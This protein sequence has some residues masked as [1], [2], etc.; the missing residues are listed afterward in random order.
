MTRASPPVAPQPPEVSRLCNKNK[1]LGKNKPKQSWEG[2]TSLRTSLRMFSRGREAAVRSQ[3]LME[4]FRD[5]RCEKCHGFMLEANK[6]LLSVQSLQKLCQC[7]YSCFF[8][9]LLQ[10]IGLQLSEE[11]T[12]ASDE[13]S[14]LFS[15]NKTYSPITYFYT[16]I[17]IYK[18]SCSLFHQMKRPTWY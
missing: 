7:W 4:R 5:Y 13:V 6:V 3:P 17:W 2:G 9:V 15:T 12:M 10:R 18:L 11:E 8:I 16:V 1:N 14:W